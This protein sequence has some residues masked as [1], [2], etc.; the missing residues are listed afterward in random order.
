MA[1]KSDKVI[2]DIVL[3]EANGM[4]KNTDGSAGRCAR[5]NRPISVGGFYTRRYGAVFG[6]ECVQY[7]DVIEREAGDGA[8]IVALV[9][10][11]R[12]RKA[13]EDTKRGLAARKARLA[14]NTVTAADLLAMGM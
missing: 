13:S 6:P 14:V 10:A 7:V 3:P 5:C 4:Y 8:D 2:F 9:V 1:D 11:A 12:L